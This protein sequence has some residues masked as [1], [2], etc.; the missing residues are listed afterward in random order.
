MKKSVAHLK[1][2]RGVLTIRLAY[3]FWERAVGLLSTKFLEQHEGMHI[4]PCAD[5]H[6]CFMRFPIDIIF[7]DSDSKILKIV[8]SVPP[9]R[10]VWG[11]KGSSSVLEMTAGASS[12]WGLEKSDKLFFE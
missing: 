12:Y 2:G 11:P 10:F 3:S 1:C 8:E 6:T 4:R 7:L 9:Y 5:V